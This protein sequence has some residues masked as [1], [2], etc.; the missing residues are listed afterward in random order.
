MKT[1]L[2][3]LL[4][5]IALSAFNLQ[6]SAATLGTAFTYQGRL[7]DGPDAAS[8]L[9]DLRFALYD[10]LA[11][12]NLVAGPLTNSLTAVTHGLFT[13]A[14]DFGASVFN[15]D[16][17]WLEIGI[18]TN[19]S[20]RGFTLLTPR[21]ALAPVPFALQAL[22]AG[23]TSVALSISQ[24]PS[25]NAV[26]VNDDLLINATN[27]GA[28]T[29]TAK[30]ATVEAVLGSLNAPLVSAALSNATFTA[31]STN[32]PTDA[33][34]TVP[35]MAI[36]IN[37]SSGGPGG[38]ILFPDW[39]GAKW[40]S[41]AAI[42]DWGEHS[43]LG[44]PGAS[45]PLNELQILPNW[46]AALAAYTAYTF[47]SDGLGPG[48]QMGGSG[49]FGD[50][51]WF[52]YN[53]AS[54]N[55]GL[56]NSKLVSF[57]TRSST[58]NVWAYASIRGVA[59][60]YTSDRASLRFRTGPYHAL[61]DTP[62]GDSIDLGGTT[63][64]GWELRGPLIQEQKQ[65]SG[66]AFCALD[67][68]AAYCVAISAAS[69]SMTFFTTNRQAA[70]TNYEHRVFVIRSGP[71]AISATWPAWAW[72][73]ATPTI[74]GPGQ[75]LRLSLESVGVGETNILATAQ[76]GT[77]PTTSTAYDPAAASFFVRAGITNSSQKLA[78][79][80][81]VLSLKAAGAWANMHAVYPFVGGTSNS[82][83]VNL[84]S[85]NYTIT[86]YGTVTH[87]ANGITGDAATGYGD[88]G[89]SPTNGLMTTS[90]AHFSV[91]Q[92]LAAN[93]FF[94]T[95]PGDAGKA[96]F[97]LGS[98]GTSASWNAIGNYV[99]SSGQY[100]NLALS[101]PNAAIEANPSLMA[102][103]HAGFDLVN[104][105]N[106]TGMVWYQAGASIYA[107]T[108]GYNSTIPADAGNFTILKGGYYNNQFSGGNVT[109]VSIGSGLDTQQAN[110]LIAAV[111]A[112]QTVLG[113]NATGQ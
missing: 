87:D 50:S 78:V 85:A 62:I 86:W 35:R 26:S 90:S 2:P 65:A 23:S 73:S 56:G 82:H 91:Y 104:R 49:Y 100:N 54:G 106:S 25:T 84:V 102:D 21:Q 105:T 10:A 44:T 99:I 53:T 5:L 46:R 107:Q 103:Y 32:L 64:N 111:N 28:G 110:A 47:Y 15:G 69:S 71:E 88:T 60:S 40:E 33:Y 51:F 101:G 95:Q 39:S 3:V 31:G 81:F 42:M 8:G 38:D 9:Y 92:R 27:N 94:P 14:L 96:G 24:Q 83:A 19:G 66:R 59:N 77:D 29:W 93:T 61:Y 1:R 4:L 97:F 41:G 89:Y 109:F 34:K 113:R 63:G 45:Q 58:S 108:T 30:R 76:I 16:A 80:A 52:Q 48:F 79:N 6:V 12:G 74:F 98:V 13:L 22:S 20:A 112:L 17:R 37:Y 57:I 11:E 36:G 67:F 72:L 18:R 43:W 68:N 75:V 70:L 55:P 7:T